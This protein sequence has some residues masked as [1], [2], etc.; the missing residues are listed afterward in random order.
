[1]IMYQLL[2][3]RTARLVLACVRG[4][5]A[6]NMYVGGLQDAIIARRPRRQLPAGTVRIQVLV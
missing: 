5:R 6:N 2:D 1:M 3:T 4:L